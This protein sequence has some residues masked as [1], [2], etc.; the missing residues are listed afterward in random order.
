MDGTSLQQ[1]ATIDLKDDADNVRYDNVSRRFW[2]GYGDGGLA[3]I[4]VQSGKQVANVKLDA[5]P[6][7]LIQ[8][9]CARRAERFSGRSQLR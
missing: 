2:V 1:T 8:F 5:H 4:D 3:A 7:S 6:E 9:E